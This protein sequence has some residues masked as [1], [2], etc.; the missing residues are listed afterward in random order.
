MSSENSK[1]SITSLLA[2]PAVTTTIGAIGSVRRNGGVK[3][4]IQAC[5]I[6]KFKGLSKALEPIHKDVFSRSVALSQN[7][8]KYRDLSKTAAKAAKKAAKAQNGK[9]PLL[10]KFLNL[11]R[12]NKVTPD[13]IIDAKNTA[14]SQLDDSIDILK[15]GGE[16]LETSTKTGF[17][18]TAKTLFKNEIKNP[19]V[20][21]MTALEL[22][23]EFT[24]KVIPAFKNEG[25]MAGLKQTGKS[26]LKVGSNF[27]SYAAGAAVG[28]ALGATIGTIICPGVGSAV[29]AS[30]GDVVGSALIGSTA[31]KVVDKITGEDSAD[32]T[33]DEAQQEIVNQASN[34]EQQNVQTSQNEQ[35]AQNQEV[36]NNQ[37]VQNESLVKPSFEEARAM[38]ATSAPSVKNLTVQKGYQKP[39]NGVYAT[40]WVNDMAQ[41]KRQSQLNT[42][43]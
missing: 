18:N 36:L 25:F 24:G 21:V 11:F 23:P 6:E 8:E 34:I 26:L 39:Q 12:K 9:I 29:G 27:I 35:I 43:S 33:A 20:I 19:I 5:E 42:L 17:K 28:R 10:D 37:Q 22:V 15:K 1:I 40:Q 14:L 41:A 16:I 31:T 13:T 4:A 38:Y 7:Y 2:F 30:I 32:E 3:N